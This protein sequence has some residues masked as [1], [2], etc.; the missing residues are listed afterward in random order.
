M[1]MRKGAASLRGV[2][3]WSEG[4]NPKC[5]YLY[6]KPLSGLIWASWALAFLEAGLIMCPPPLIDLWR[7]A[8]QDDINIWINGGSLFKVTA[9]INI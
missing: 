1:I 8:H 4:E 7:R 3:E 5:L 6:S 2:R 9:S